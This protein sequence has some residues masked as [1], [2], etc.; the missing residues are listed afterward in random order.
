VK[1]IVD[2][3][4]QA[5]IAESTLIMVVS[6]HGGIFHKHGDNTSEEFNVPIIF[7]GKGVK[8]N[9][10]IRQQIYKYDVAANIAFAL[11]VQAPQVWV[12][13]PT[14]AAYEGFDEPKNLWTDGVEVLP[15]P[16]FASKTYY[17]PHGDLS[18]DRPV[19]VNILVPSGVE[20]EIRYTT[21][22][23][24]PTRASTLYKGTFPLD[25]SAVVTAR[26]FSANGESSQAVAQYR[27][28]D[29][30]A[31]NGLNYAFYHHPDAKEMP[32]FAAMKPVATGVTY[33]IGM[34]TPELQALKNRYKSNFGVSYS[35]WIQIDEP[36]LYTF[37]LWSSGGHRLYINSDLILT[38]SILD[39]GGTSGQVE[40]QKGVYPVK[41]DFFSRGGSE[42]DLYYSSAGLKE[43]MVP[44]NI[45]Y[46]IEKK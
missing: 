18:V 12:G 30:K 43:R 42:A 44:A 11:G 20:G 24:T 15:P 45:L 34:K 32:S 26:L 27:V 25:R 28:A 37:T 21:D 1:V 40:L 4:Q 3:I 46:R 35:G 7:S 19:E 39:G 6:D 41:V 33:E 9:Y 5:G 36:G 2:A 23:S 22:G 29:T 31:G 38:K 10:H 8:K 14:Q 16:R 17:P 13:R